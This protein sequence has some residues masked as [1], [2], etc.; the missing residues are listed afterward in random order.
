VRI[1]PID[2]KWKILIPSK[3]FRQ[4]RRLQPKERD[5]IIKAID[6]LEN[7]PNQGDI[8]D[9]KPDP[10]WRLRVGERRILF[11]IDE[12]KRNIGITRI[13]QRGDVYKK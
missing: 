13:G 6:G 12:E 4:V 10:E 9:L 3:I 7:F 5:R 8:K 2:R 11:R 1:L